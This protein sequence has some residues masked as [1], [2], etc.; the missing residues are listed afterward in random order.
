MEEGGEVEC[1][2]NKVLR[3][4]DGSL[5][6]REKVGRHQQVCFR[7][8]I[9]RVNDGMWGMRERGNPRSCQRRQAQSM[10]SFLL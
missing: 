9:G 8:R 2:M 6:C 7:R 3:E 5:D 1:P 10:C 4:S